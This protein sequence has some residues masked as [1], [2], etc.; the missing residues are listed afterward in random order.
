MPSFCK[1][2]VPNDDRLSK[3]SDLNLKEE[4]PTFPGEIFSHA[5]QAGHI[6][7][8]K[9]ATLPSLSIP[10]EE[11]KLTVERV[12]HRAKRQMMYAGAA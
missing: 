4:D 7:K 9:E 10:R 3:P 11:S 5:Q 2:F 8:M 6:S 12:I 1:Q